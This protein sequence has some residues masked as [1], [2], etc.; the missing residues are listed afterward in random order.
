M[1]CILDKKMGL[2]TIIIGCLILLSGANNVITGQTVKETFEVPAFSGV[3]LA[4]PGSAYVIQGTTPKVEIEAEKSTLDLISIEADGDVLNFR[5]KDKYWRK[6]GD[7]KIYITMS[8]I[9]HL[10]V[11]GSCDLLCEGEIKSHE[12]DLKISG[13]GSININKLTA[14]EVD[15]EITG[16]G[17]IILSGPTELHE[18]D[19]RI[20]G[21][22]NLKTLGIAVSEA[23]VN[24]TG[25]GSAHVFV[26][27]ELETK[28][29]GSG[30]VM[31]KGTPLVN[32]NVIGSGKTR[33]LD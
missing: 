19:A 28:I 11:A 25:S 8:E 24:I 21:S 16:S 3:S 30:D 13:S 18:L 27:K 22:G 9:G 29:T 7:I 2:I 33:S 5:I 32:A 23:S 6:L 20:T 12:L 4:L 26:K 10:A 15:A 17:D 31:Y 1:K 14:H